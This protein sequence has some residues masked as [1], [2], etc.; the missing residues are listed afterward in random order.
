VTDA[1]TCKAEIIALHCLFE[2][3]LGA[4]GGDPAGFDAAF[5]PGFT[6]VMPNGR[7][8]DR[9]G[10]LD[11]LRGARGVRGA[12]FRIAIEEAEAL[13]LAPPLVLM[14][15]LERQWIGPV[16]TARRATALFRVEAGRAQWLSV[17]ETWVTPPP[18]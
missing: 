13:H 6:M 4:G 8:L 9:A 16:E 14:H 5:A 10:A 11:F 2:S 12:G 3:W 7:R 18:A 1:E 15:Y 17:Q